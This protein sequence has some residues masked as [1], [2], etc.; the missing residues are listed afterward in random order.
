ME[1]KSP[2]KMEFFTELNF[3]QLLSLLLSLSIVTI[4]FVFIT[5]IIIIVVEQG[6]ESVN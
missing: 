1:L 6:Y 5:I 3:K 2:F 4:S